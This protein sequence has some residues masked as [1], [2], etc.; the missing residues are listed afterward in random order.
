MTPVA[1]SIQP[2]IDAAA[3][4]NITVE[5]VSTVSRHT[6]TNM[7]HVSVRRVPEKAQNHGPHAGCDGAPQW[8]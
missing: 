8:A 1:V 7:R 3:T 4:M 2:K 6:L 5:V